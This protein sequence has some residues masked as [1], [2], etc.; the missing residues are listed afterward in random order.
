MRSEIAYEPDHDSPV[1]GLENKQEKQVILIADDS[2]VE[3]LLTRKAIE[4]FGFEVI[5]ATDGVEMPGS[6]RPIRSRFGLAGCGHA[7]P[8]RL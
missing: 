6:C 7:Q 2:D 4:P 5:E 1:D 3:R 8:G